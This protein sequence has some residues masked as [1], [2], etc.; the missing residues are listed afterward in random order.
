MGD[1]ADSVFPQHSPANK[2]RT[3]VL[4]AL[5]AGNLPI[6]IVVF[7][8]GQQPTRLTLNVPGLQLT[9]PLP[10]LPLRQYSSHDDYAAKILDRNRLFILPATLLR[11]MVAGHRRHRRGAVCCQGAVHL[12]QL[13]RP[14]FIAI[15]L[16]R[17]QGYV[18]AFFQMFNPGEYK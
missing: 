15:A 1:P 13:A 16:C 7:P 11:Q 17:R 5:A 8:L 18:L 2:V 10:F 12:R 9:P 14:F 3:P 4:V 6:S